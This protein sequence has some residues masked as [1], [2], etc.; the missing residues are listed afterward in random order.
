VLEEGAA[1]IPKQADGYGNIQQDHSGRSLEALRHA[2]GIVS[3]H[4][5]LFAGDRFVVQG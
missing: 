4:H 2:R 5:P 1:R 3:F